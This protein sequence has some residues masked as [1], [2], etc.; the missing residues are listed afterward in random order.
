MFCILHP[1]KLIHIFP[2]SIRIAPYEKSCALEKQGR[3]GGRE[4]V[5]QGRSTAGAPPPASTAAG[6]VAL[7]PALANAAGGRITH[8]VHDVGDTVLVRPPDEER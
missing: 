1:D 5:E 7:P 2:N 4:A 6:G 3:W 8:A